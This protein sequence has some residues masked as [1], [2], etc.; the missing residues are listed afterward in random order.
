MPNYEKNTDPFFYMI[1]IFMAIAF[2]VFGIYFGIIIAQAISKTNIYF[3]LA[4]PLTAYFSHRIYKKNLKRPKAAVDYLYVLGMEFV[5]IISFAA[6]GSLLALL[7]M[8]Y[9]K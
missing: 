5:Y 2:F 4:L 1:G 3:G 9:S 7:F 6:M 8:M